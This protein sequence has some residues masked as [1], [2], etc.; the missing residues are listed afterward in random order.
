MTVTR[1]MIMESSCA[2]TVNFFIGL[3]KFWNI[4]WLCTNLRLLDV[5]LT[6]T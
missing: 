1:K 2:H 5:M 4:E 3:G 6:A